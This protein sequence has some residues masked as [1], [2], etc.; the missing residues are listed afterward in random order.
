MPGITWLKKHVCEQKV[1]MI[2]Y[3]FDAVV[4]Y[5]YSLLVTHL[6]M[7]QDLGNRVVKDAVETLVRSMW[8]D[9]VKACIHSAWIICGG[10]VDATIFQQEMC[11]DVF[12]AVVEAVWVTAKDRMFTRPANTIPL[13]LDDGRILYAKVVDHGSITVM[14][15]GTKLANTCSARNFAHAIC[16]ARFKRDP[17]PDD[18]HEWITTLQLQGGQR[19][20][21]SN[22]FKPIINDAM[23]T[24]VVLH[25]FQ[26]MPGNDNYYHAGIYQ[27]PGDILASNFAARTEAFVLY[28][29]Y[30]RNDVGKYEGHF[31]SLI[32]VPVEDPVEDPEESQTTITLS[33]A[34]S[35]DSGD[36]EVTQDV[37]G[38]HER[39]YVAQYGP[40]SKHIM[41]LR[42]RDI[43]LNNGKCGNLRD[44]NALGDR[45]FE[46]M[47]SDK[48]VNCII[49]PCRSGK[50]LLMASKILHD[51][52]M[53]RSAIVLLNHPNI[54]AAIALAK[55]LRFYTGLAAAVP[56]TMN[57]VVLHYPKTGKFEPVNIRLLKRQ[58]AF[59]ITVV[60]STT[61]NRLRALHETLMGSP[62]G[63][64]V[65]HFDE[66]QCFMDVLD[67]TACH[68][69]I[70]LDKTKK[71]A[72]KEVK[73]LM[74]SDSGFRFHQLNLYSATHFDTAMVLKTLN[75]NQNVAIFDNVQHLQEI[76]YKGCSDCV[77][78]AANTKHLSID[79]VWTSPETTVFVQ[80]F[81]DT[82]HGYLLCLG[83]SFVDG[84]RSR[85]AS[86]TMDS[87]A[88]QVSTKMDPDCTDVLCIGVSANK[89]T[90]YKGGKQLAEFA[91]T[92]KA[93]HGVMEQLHDYMR[94][95]RGRVIVIP[96]NADEGSVEFRFARHTVTHVIV[97]STSGT[98][99]EKMLQGIGRSWGM[100]I[101]HDINVFIH[102]DVWQELKQWLLES[103]QRLLQQVGQARFITSDQL[104]ARVVR[105]DRVGHSKAKH[106]DRIKRVLDYRPVP[107]EEAGPSGMTSKKA[108]GTIASFEILAKLR[109]FA[110]ATVPSCVTQV[111]VYP[112][113]QITTQ[114]V[115]CQNSIRTFLE[116]PGYIGV[117]GF[118][119]AV[120]R[121]EPRWFTSFMQEPHTLMPSHYRT[122]WFEINDTICFITRMCAL[123]EI[124]QHADKSG[125]YTFHHVSMDMNGSVIDAS[126]R[127]ANTTTVRKVR[128]RT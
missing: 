35:D 57:R 7:L 29:Y 64:I 62:A 52:S 37:C 46:F 94:T 50:T 89:A 26:K 49:S 114:D 118:G 107:G 2:V 12:T 102:P 18:I 116:Q 36:D 101:P 45:L 30:G 4:R 85:T 123:D 24:G 27:R 125:D 32:I 91:A 53:G 117:R 96:N 34:S 6:A 115:I 78:H 84:S 88:K 9:V 16:G 120:S 38:P 95:Y 73:E 121:L 23:E 47:M 20:I 87:I 106:A 22:R 33:R 104:E 5:V 54:D 108:R 61:D 67:D 13:K 128:T 112:R 103:Q 1:T 10:P 75:M 3:N 126:I 80:S 69:D 127:A 99:Y 21:M 65:I 60:A 109:A 11:N 40:T 82:Q 74:F 90:A 110:T 77:I 55:S 83:G 41:L 58:K 28:E 111:Y 51:Y 68:V 93:D 59:P 63:D 48:L 79:R 66:P 42:T 98:R 71:R 86:K 56:D 8:I 44:V 31:K 100:G 14:P 43:H 70:K 122:V 19:D 113:S 76:G 119:S 105:S 92:K 25:V 39:T 81:L 97:C 72:V 15:N 124:I 17:L